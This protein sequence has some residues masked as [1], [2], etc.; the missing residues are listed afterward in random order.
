MNKTFDWTYATGY[1][2]PSNFWD[3]DEIKSLS[4]ARENFN[5]ED[6]INVWKNEGFNP[7]VGHLFDMRHP[8][9]PKTTDKLI[10]WSEERGLH[11]VGV[12]YYAMESGDNLPYHFDTYKK[13]IE[14]FN[15]ENKKDKIYR[16]IFF[17]EDRKPGHIL[18]VAGKLFDW[19][20]GTYVA[21]RY[22]TEHMAANFGKHVRY[23][24][25]LTGVIL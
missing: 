1:V 13:Y 2:D 17:P 20:A 10:K 7:R 14:L 4:Y 15:L 18:E 23:S 3:I 22:D 25:Q 19:K 8:D 12:S 24:I 9:Q 11:H 16:Y 21:W 6:Q 5:N